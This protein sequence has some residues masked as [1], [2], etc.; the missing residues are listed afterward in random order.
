MGVNFDFQLSNTGSGTL[1]CSVKQH[2]VV[3]WDSCCRSC[4]NMERDSWLEEKSIFQ[5]NMC[6]QKSAN[7]LFSSVVF[8]PS[9]SDCLLA[10]HLFTVSEYT[11]AL[12]AIKYYF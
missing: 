5:E 2:T 4:V 11:T 6:C 7:F 1:D 9:W 12:L 3:G 10:G 8:P